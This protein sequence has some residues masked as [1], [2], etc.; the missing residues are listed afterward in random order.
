MLRQPRFW[1]LNAALLL[2][3]VWTLTE[4]ATVTVQVAAGQCTA[5]FRSHLGRAPARLPALG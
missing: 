2:L 1:L 4:T 3:Y 5:V